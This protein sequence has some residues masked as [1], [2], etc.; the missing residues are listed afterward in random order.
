MP[1]ATLL[2]VS[3]NLRARNTRFLEEV[4]GHT[5]MHIRTLY[6]SSAFIFGMNISGS[7]DRRQIEFDQTDE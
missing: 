4:S 5:Y 7:I 1:T 3:L 6:E 2:E